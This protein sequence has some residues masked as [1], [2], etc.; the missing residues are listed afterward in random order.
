MCVCPDGGS[1]VT[2][3]HDTLDLILQPP[4]PSPGSGPGP[5]PSHPVSDIWWPLLKTCSNLFTWR[6]SIS[7]YWHLVAIKARSVDKQ[8]VRILLKCF[9]VAS[10]FFSSQKLQS[11]KFNISEFNK[12][13]TKVIW[14]DQH[15]NGYS[16]TISKDRT[17]I[18]QRHHSKY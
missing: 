13:S 2:I 14:N 16:E 6:P 10:I 4:L 3:T 15:N 9:L 18:H 7:T 8:V 12:N 17:R 11:L 1:Q 5:D